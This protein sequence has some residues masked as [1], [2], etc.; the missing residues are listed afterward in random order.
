LAVNETETQINNHTAYRE[1]MTLLATCI[2]V[3]TCWI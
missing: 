2:V 3:C 1:I